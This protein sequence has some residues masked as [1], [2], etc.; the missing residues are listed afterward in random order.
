MSARVKL[1]VMMFLQYFIW[2]AWYVTMGTYLSTTLKFDGTQV[3]M[4]YGTTAI[5]AMVS[6]FFVGMIA[7]RFFPTQRVIALLHIAGAVALYLVSTA[8]TF[9]R[10]YPL[11]IL[12]ALFYM[13]TLALSNSIS[14]HN[15][16][17]SARDFPRIRVLG[18]IGWIAAGILVGRLGLEATAMPMRIAAGASV[19]LALYSLALPHTPPQAAGKPFSIRDVLGLD[20]L[21]LLK[22]RSFTTF[23]V[24]SF[25]LCIPLQFYYAFTNLFLN[26]TGLPE[27]ATKMTLGQMSEIG[28]MLL[29]PLA[30]VRLGVKRIMLIGMA[31]WSL[32]Y[33]LFAV[34]D[35]GSMVWALYLG[36]LLHGICYDFFFVTGQ[37]YVDQQAGNRIRAAAQGLI[38]FVTLGIGLYIGSWVSGKVV[39]AYAVTGST[40][41]LSHDWQSIWMVPAIGAAV[42]LVVFAF[43]FRP[44]V[45]QPRAAVPSTN[46]PDPLP[47]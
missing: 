42:I 30:L 17:D 43:L 9:G 14:F 47:L 24:G 27:P 13:P 33:A 3:G 11:L 26:E 10:F 1:S 34:G 40:G 36:I 7:D 38:A 44:T 39:D 32:R 23:V 22:D 5:A 6:P 20:A 37:I 2:G 41:I 35:T 4:A 29:L 16:S 28:F 19:L 15:M 45:A 18:T 12:Y 25:L 31:A 8:E 46:Q 21:A